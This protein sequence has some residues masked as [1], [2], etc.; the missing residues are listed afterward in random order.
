MQTVR[1]SDIPHIAAFMGDFWNFIK[2]TWNVG[3]S[4]DW[5]GQAVRRANEICEKY[6]HPFVKGQIQAYL[7]YISDVQKEM[8]KGENR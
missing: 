8:L 5:S 7:D 3:L 2:A 6:Q 4:D 1:K